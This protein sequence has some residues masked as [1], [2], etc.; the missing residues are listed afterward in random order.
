MNTIKKLVLFLFA[1]A[2]VAGCNKASYKKTKGG[3]PYQLFKGNDT[4]RIYPGNFVKIQLIQKIKDSVYYSTEGKLPLF[5]QVSSTPQPYDLSELWTS[6]RVGDSVITT[7]MMDT[8]INRSPMNISPEF[9][10]GDRIVTYVKV[11][12]IFASDSLAR[13]DDEKNKKE[14]TVNEVKALEKYM[15]DKKINAQKTP[16]GAFVEIITPGTGNLI[17]SGKYVSLD[18][19][20]K[21]WSG[22]TFDSN[23]D[24]AF[25]HDGPL[26]FTAGTGAMIKGF[27]EGI[28]FLRLGTKAKI[29]IPSMIAFGANSGNPSIK[30]YENV[31]FDVTVLD[32]KDK[33]PAPATQRPPAPVNIPPQ[34]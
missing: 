32:V 24:T 25:K 6:L 16:S 13:L 11:I 10:K 17:D 12:A 3:M 27:D 15:T 4:Q 1:A 28:L 26:S 29:Y 5:L 22:K 31:I 18:Y 33:A 7:Q 8:F 20:G 34:K 19:T 23:V 2:I 30:P 14:Y 21:T 9:K